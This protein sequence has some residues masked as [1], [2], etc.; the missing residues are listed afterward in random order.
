MSEDVSRGRPPPSRKR[1]DPDCNGIG[2]GRRSRVPLSPVEFWAVD[3]SESAPD[4]LA[5]G[6]A[7][8]QGCHMYRHSLAT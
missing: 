1:F 3:Q 6:V 8:Y 5:L 4:I 7:D 2:A